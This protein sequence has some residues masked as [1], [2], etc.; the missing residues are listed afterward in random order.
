MGIAHR[1]SAARRIGTSL[2]LVAAMSLAASAAAAEEGAWIGIFTENGPEDMSEAASLE[3]RLDKR[4]ASMM[5]FTDFGHPFPLQAARNA[6]AAGAV[7]N[8]TW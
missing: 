8:I 5:W 6:A 7:P 2:A 3:R 1:A 4:F